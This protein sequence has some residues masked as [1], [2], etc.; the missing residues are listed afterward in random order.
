MGTCSPSTSAGHP[1][2]FRTPTSFWQR[3]S[4]P[5]SPSVCA[6][7]TLLM[8]EHNRL[9]TELAAD[10]PGW[11][12]EAVYQRTRKMVGAQV[13]AITY[14]EFLP[15]LLGPNAPGRYTGYDP[16]IN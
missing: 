1:T 12:D 16:T 10:N 13:Q 3:T 2:R 5:T 9:A 6:L 14:H 4:G 8:R 15:A 7:Q 11:S